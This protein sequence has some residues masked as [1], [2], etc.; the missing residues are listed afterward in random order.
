MTLYCACLRLRLRK[1]P[2]PFHSIESQ[3]IRSLYA[4]RMK[5]LWKSPLPPPLLPSL[6]LEGWIREIVPITTANCAPQKSAVRN[7]Y[8][9]QQ[10]IENNNLSLICASITVYIKWKLGSFFHVPTHT[11][12]HTEYLEACRPSSR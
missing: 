1:V 6:R 4:S 8:A 5:Q 7:S 12:L 11:V 2:H 10:S 3:S 9:G